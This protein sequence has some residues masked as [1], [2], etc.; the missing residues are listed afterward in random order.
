MNNA[1]LTTI[2]M[3]GAIGA[4]FY[5]ILLR[6]QQKQKK[7]HDAMLRSLRRGDEVVTAGGLVGEV[8]YI[9]QQ[10]KDGNTTVSMDDRVTLKSGE[11]RLIVE[12]GRIAKITR[13]TATSGSAG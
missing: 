13:T 3:Y 6:P 5:F 8:T 9:A 10:T 11:T 2:V 1:L 4:I 7:E 12:R